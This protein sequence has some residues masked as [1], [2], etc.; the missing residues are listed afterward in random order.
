MA[1]T[2]L[3]VGLDVGTTNVKAVAFDPAGRVVADDSASTPTERPRPGWAEHEPEA[4]WRTAARVV[5][6]TTAKLSRPSRVAGL[7]VASVAEAG[8]GL[9]DH[10][11]P[12][13]PVI[14]WFDPRAET[15]AA[16]LEARVGTERLMQVTGL[17][18]QPI[19][20]LCKL[21]WL[22]DNEPEAFARI[23]V[24]LNVA[25]YLA[26]R[27][28]GVQATDRSLAS[29][30]AAYDLDNG[31]WS[32][33]VLAAVD[34]DPAIFAPLVDSGTALGTITQEAAGQT[35]LATHTRVAAGGHDHV[36]G[37]LAAGILGPERLLDSMGTAESFLVAVDRRPAG[38][39]ATRQGFSQGAHVVPGR[40]YVAGGLHAAGASLQWAL[41]LVAADDDERSRLTAE[42][43][44]VPP[45]ARGVC[46]LPHLRFG[47][48]PNPDPAARGALVGLT[49]DVDRATV[50][51]AV[52]EGLAYAFRHAV[53]ALC[54]QTGLAPRQV[55]AIGGG[56]RNELL[57]RLK[58]TLLD[59]PVTVLDVEEATSLGAALLGA[60]GAG[61]YDDVEQAVTGLAVATEEVNGDQ[62][63]KADYEARFRDL[64]EGL[65][66][67]LRDVNHAIHQFES[68]AGR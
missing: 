5:R 22:R 27:L 47:S 28:C 4:L 23:A 62:S 13:G 53:D 1:D 12:V 39:E 61:V 17:R 44:G 8:V 26:Y 21:M 33:E 45:G 42:A 41:D 46:F 50:V 16:E 58:A 38:V 20:G 40:W 60:V 63:L 14:A 2:P 67:D 10:G 65:Y 11:R 30:T 48:P 34:V 59:R 51:R 64:Y 32:E 68:G 18:P 25:D 35:D 54:D 52:L 49:A 29:R 57:V 55:R 19:Y 66:A 36:C 37:A 56:A 24:W 6:G 3:V 9:D 31:S 7:A 15:Q 43:A